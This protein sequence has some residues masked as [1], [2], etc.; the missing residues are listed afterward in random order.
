[1]SVKT[2]EMKGICKSFPGVKALDNI[3]LE[4]EKGDVLA[5]LGEN[6]AGKSTLMKVLSGAYSADEG[7]ILIDGETVEIKDP[8][9]AISKGI[10]VIYQELNNADVLSIAENIFM[11][12]LKSN[13]AGLIDYKTISEDTNKLLKRVGLEKYDANTLVEDLSIAE[14]QMVEIAKA[15]SKNTK[16]LV[17]DEPTAALTDEETD[18]LFDL[19]KQLSSEGT[20]IIYISHRLEEV[21]RISNKVMVMRDGCLVKTLETKDTTKDELISLM[22]G[23]TIENVYPER[24]F[25]GD[26]SVLLEVNNLSTNNYVKNVSFNV[27]KGEV[28]GLFGLMGAG[29]TDIIEAIFGDKELETGEIL[30]DGQKVSIKSPE[31]AKKLGIGYLP[32]DRKAEGLFL[33]HSIAQNISA[34][35]IDKICGKS[36]LINSKLEEELA[37]KWIDAIKIK[38]PSAQTEAETLSGGN[39]Q[40]VV[41]AKWLAADPRLLMLNEPTRGIDVGAKLEIYNLMNDL[42]DKGISFIMV[43]SELPEIMAMSD[44]IYVIHEGK[45]KGEVAREDF[46]QEKLLGIAI[47][48]ND[49]E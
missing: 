44:R 45:L 21:F 28:V 26:G 22:V 8:K 23:R 11:G 6:G 37:A 17:L 20:S 2:L 47:G 27:K 41:V 35:V 16:I 14:K 36:G 9:D 19:V 24:V 10:N 32:S 42:T 40:K 25:K 29:R 49:N 1:M 15:L 12:N 48:G 34:N 18:I 7:T 43:S 30:M 31:D 46:S 3:N 13:K 4:L 38:T 5:L 39:Q 33:I